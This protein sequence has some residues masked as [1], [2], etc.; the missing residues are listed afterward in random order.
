MTVRVS[1]SFDFDVPRERI[2]EFIADP[3]KRAGAIR[4]VDRFDVHED[5]TA[6]WHV[7]LPI[8]LVRS[9]IDVETEEVIRTPPERVK[10]VGRSR[11][12]TVT[13]EHRV[14]ETETGCRLENEFV[15]D[16][17]L[18]GVE[19]FFERNFDAELKNL[20]AALHADIRAN[21][22]GESA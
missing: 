22:R 5:G 12:F 2:W 4:V 18:P 14:V 21:A 11:A 8:P 9:T 10:F 13:G 7:E 16:G 17:R 15:V 1:R 6:T 20:E 3:E 19:R